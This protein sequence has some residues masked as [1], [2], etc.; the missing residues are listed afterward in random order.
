M[1]LVQSCLFERTDR[2]FNFNLFVW[3]FLKG[4]LSCLLHQKSNEQWV[5]RHI[6]NELTTKIDAY[7]LSGQGGRQSAKQQRFVSKF[8]DR[9][10]VYPMK[11]FKLFT[12]NNN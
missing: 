10:N 1:H 11:W 12:I 5:D 3:L 2:Q 6:G 8:K 9:I 4:A 7:F